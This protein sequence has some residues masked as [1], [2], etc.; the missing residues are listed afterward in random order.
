MPSVFSLHHQ[1]VLRRTH[2]R[3]YVN[4]TRPHRLNRSKRGGFSYHLFVSAKLR[5]I[6]SP[7]GFENLGKWHVQCNGRRNRY[8][9]GAPDGNVPKLARDVTCFSG[10]SSRQSS[11][12]YPKSHFMPSF[13]H[14]WD[15]ELFSRGFHG[16]FA[17]IGYLENGI[18]VYGVEMM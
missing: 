8:V 14:R 11:R 17:Y 9:A 7:A 2:V 4:H 6:L 1:S 13:R 3:Y 10:R 18:F 15:L 16:K 5:L 12:S